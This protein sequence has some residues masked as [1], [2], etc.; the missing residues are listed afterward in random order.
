MKEYRMKCTRCGQINE[1]MNVDYVDGGYEGEPHYSCPYC[2]HDD[3]DEVFQCAECGEWFTEDE[4]LEDLCR[5]CFDKAAT[6]ESVKEY[7][8]SYGTDVEVNSLYACAFTTAQ[9][10]AILAREFAAL[11]GAEQKKAAADA[12]CDDPYNFREWARAAV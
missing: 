4:L 5:D 9:I 11:N 1:E 12:A 6:V 10:N 7:G 8:A 3:W 2:G